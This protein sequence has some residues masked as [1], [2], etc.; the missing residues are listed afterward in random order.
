LR[1]LGVLTTRLGDE[2]QSSVVQAPAGVSPL[3][4][5]QVDGIVSL[6]IEKKKA[7]RNGSN[8]NR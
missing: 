7:S 1:Y 8:A 2:A 6:K 3:L 4:L 5:L